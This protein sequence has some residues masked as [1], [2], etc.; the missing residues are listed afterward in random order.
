MELHVTNLESIQDILYSNYGISQT[1]SISVSYVK[2]YAINFKMYYSLFNWL[3]I[4]KAVE[5]SKNV[6]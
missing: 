5:T 1:N 6:T 3:H 2:I 4:I